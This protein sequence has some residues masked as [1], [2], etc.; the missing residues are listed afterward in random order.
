[1]GMKAAFLITVS[2]ALLLAGCSEA[3]KGQSRVEALD[4]AE[5]PASSAAIAP[6]A[7]EAAAEG[8]EDAADASAGS[9]SVEA[10]PIKVAAAPRIAYTYEFGYRLDADAI[11]T[12]QRAHADLCEKAGPMNCRI[13]NLQASG[14]EG[15]YASARLELDVAA[16][17]ARAFAADLGK[18]VEASGG[19]ETEASITGEDL[20][21]QIVDT[22]ARL[23]ARVVLRDRLMEVLQSRRGT[24]AELVEAERGVAQ[25]NEE[26]DQAR[27][28]LAEMQGRV[29]FSRMTIQYRSGSVSGGGFIAPI[30]DALNN[31]GELLGIMIGGLIMLFTALLPLG[32]IGWGIWR[33]VRWYRARQPAKA[34]APPA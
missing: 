18:A 21:K 13:I 17:K 2:A 15:D 1:M 25:V 29:D 3:E 10:G 20:S 26:I 30:R 19:E 33:L 27:S 34:D 28:W 24:V 11:G 32:L 23:R 22:E 8:A 7:A 4:V 31:T 6:P 12:T 9:A 14:G 5:A 16:P